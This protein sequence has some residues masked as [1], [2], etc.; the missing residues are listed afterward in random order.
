MIPG[1][2]AGRW[3]EPIFDPR[4]IALIGASE[5]TGSVGRALTENLRAFPGTTYL[6][7]PKHQHIFDRPSFPNLRSLPGQVD[8]AVIATPAHTAPDIMRDCVAAGVP[9]AIILSAGFHETGKAGAELEQRVLA[10]A[11]KGKVR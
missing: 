11:A 7:N 5:R 1:A 8:L 2:D 3:F 10:E 4:A 9:G 6:V